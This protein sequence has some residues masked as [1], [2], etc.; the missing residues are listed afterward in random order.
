MMPMPMHPCCVRLFP[1]IRCCHNCVLEID[2]L[3]L[4]FISYCCLELAAR[5]HWSI[6][7]FAQQL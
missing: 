6:W 2:M 4:S 1:E 7:L 3:P 5:A